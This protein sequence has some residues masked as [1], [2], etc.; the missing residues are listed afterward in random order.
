MS[1]KFELGDRIVIGKQVSSNYAGKP[2]VVFK[3]SDN[4]KEDYW[5]RFDDGVAKLFSKMWFEENLTRPD[6]DFDDIESGDVVLLTYRVTASGVATNVIQ[7]K[8]RTTFGTA[9]LVS[10]TKEA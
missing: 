2:G 7:D 9:N 4:Y 8:N 6:L 3:Q 5:V 1:V 10:I